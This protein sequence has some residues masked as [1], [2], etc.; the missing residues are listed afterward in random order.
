MG[1]VS[2]GNAP[3][4]SSRLN[5]LE[6]ATVPIAI[7]AGYRF[8]GAHYLGGTIVWG[9]GIAPNAGATC[10]PQYSCFRQ[11]AQVRFEARQYLDPSARWGWWLGAGVGWEVATFSQSRDGASVTRTFTGPV[12]ANLDLGVDARRDLP[13]IGPYL[14]VAVAEFVSQGLNPSSTPVSTWIPSPGLH[15]WITLGLRGSWGPW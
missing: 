2:S 7:D 15:A 4:L 13:A 6:T 1:S 8:S 3:G 11:D 12:F 14:G 9:P 5:D 10:P